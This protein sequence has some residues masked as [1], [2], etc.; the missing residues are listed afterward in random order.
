MKVTLTVVEGPNLGREYVYEQRD[1]FLVGRTPAAHLC[2]SRDRFFSRHHFMVEVNPPNVYLL[3]LHSTNGTSVNSRKNKVEEAMLEDGDIVIGGETKLKVTIDLSL[4]AAAA[5]EECEARESVCC[6][7]C[8]QQAER[9]QARST[10]EAVTFI[11]Q[12]CQDNMRGQ[13]LL[14]DGYRLV[15]ELG[16]GS[17]GSVYLAKDA[18]G[19]PRAIKLV[20]PNA[21]LSAKAREQFL[22]QTRAQA[23]LKHPRIVRV[24]AIV[25]PR[26]GVFCVIME[27]VEG[28]ALSELLTEQK[29]LPCGMALQ[30]A[31]Q[32]LEGLAYAH[33][34]GIVHRDIKPANVL[35]AG[36]SAPA[37][38]VKLA[39]FGLAQ[40]YEV[41]G[42]SGF[43]RL[44]EV[45]RAL[46]YKAPEQIIDFRGA[47]PA[48]DLYAVAAV[49]YR[50]LSGATPYAL[51]K[52]RDP[53]LALL[54]D[55]IVPL[56]ERDS[57]IA[58]AVASVIEKGLAKSPA[59][60]HGSAAEMRDALLAVAVG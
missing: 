60:R 20:M 29:K 9:E 38:A 15:R 12:A 58:S 26:D 1:R 44:D 51:D 8:G 23:R 28:R 24:F 19:A 40:S 43:A 47:D 52:G 54:E 25:Q 11:C 17:M 30:I 22:T 42:A 3:D 32:M 6:L 49:S 7:N 37:P 56:R 50:M 13:P 57:S 4:E 5:G 21:A 16:R 33:G 55:D 45:D 34:E 59:D 35:L 48:A 27:H 18:V 2:V 46:A 14:P 36:D 10:S 41:T 53:F 31:A 39:D